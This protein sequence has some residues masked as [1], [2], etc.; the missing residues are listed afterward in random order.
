MER[1]SRHINNALLTHI[2][3]N[4]E[5][6]EY[7]RKRILLYSPMR[8]AR[9]LTYIDK[10]GYIGRISYKYNDEFDENVKNRSNDLLKIT[11]EDVY[12]PYKIFNFDLLT[13]N[14]E[15][16]LICIIKNSIVL[17]EDILANILKLKPI[18]RRKNELCSN[19]KYMSKVIINMPEYVWINVK[20]K[21]H[22]QAYKIKENDL[23]KSLSESSVNPC[24]GKNIPKNQCFS[25]RKKYSINIKFYRE[26]Y[27]Q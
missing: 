12:Y 22:N 21:Y 18:K 24:S 25:L 9:I 26:A 20:D 14:E 4:D 15:S 23:I 16:K 1:L 6:I 8:A 2:S 3:L 10:R 11:L 7:A 5:D 13:K 17:N 19:E 27:Q